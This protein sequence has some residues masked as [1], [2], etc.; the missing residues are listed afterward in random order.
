[1]L[2]F[3]VPHVE[4][5]SNHGALSYVLGIVRKTSISIGFCFVIIKLE[6]QKLFDFD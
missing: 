5:L 6:V 1:L 4:E 3:F 2:V